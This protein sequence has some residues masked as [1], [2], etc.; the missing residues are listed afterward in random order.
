MILR[1]NYDVGSISISSFRKKARRNRNKGAMFLRLAF[2]SLLF[3]NQ[4]IKPGDV[5]VH[6][7]IKS[8]EV[9]RNV[10]NFRN[11]NLIT[12]TATAIY[13]YKSYKYEEQQLSREFHRSGGIL[14]KKSILKDKELDVIRS[15]LSNLLSSS[16]S[17]K[18]KPKQK[19]PRANDESPL[20]MILNDETT[21]SV[22]INRVGAKLPWDCQTIQVLENPEGSLNKL[23]N[24]LIEEDVVEDKKSKMILS[25]DVPVEVRVYE[26]TGSGMVSVFNSSKIPIC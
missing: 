12:T 24:D 5:F 10:N 9:R 13:V 17:V 14:Y 16:S 15:E 23:L 26:K 11:K 4:W 1:V 3:L 21:S 7:F 19:K 6:G 18:S 25:R 20:P 22:A 8:Y 2:L